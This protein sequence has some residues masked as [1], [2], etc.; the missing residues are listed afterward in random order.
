MT[1]LWIVVAVIIFALGSIMALKPSGLEQRLD[2]LRMTA[3]RLEL[4]PKLIACPEWIRG[5]DNEYGKG[6]MAQY[7]LIIDD[8]SLPFSRYLAID[9]QWRVQLDNTN[10]QQSTEKPK[11]EQFILDKVALGLP[12]IIEPFVK[13]L[14]TKANSISIYWNDIEYVRPNRQ[15]AYQPERIEP[16]LQ[17]LKQQLIHWQSLIQENSQ[18]KPK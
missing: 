14:Q 6:M 3:R 18:Q 5:K 4:N 16:D 1:G 7:T 17:Q 2:K 11:K 8:I 12:D 10:T 9:R 15:G 13:G